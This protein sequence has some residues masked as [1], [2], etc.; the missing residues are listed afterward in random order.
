M[1][2]SLERK[3]TTTVSPFSRIDVAVKARAMG[4]RADFSFGRGESAA[5]TLLQLY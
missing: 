2:G 4:Q 3:V 1:I 5:A